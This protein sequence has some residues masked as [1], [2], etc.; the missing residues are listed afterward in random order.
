MKQFDLS[1]TIVGTFLEPDQREAIEGLGDIRVFQPGELLVRKGE[2]SDG[3]FIIVDGQ[4]FVRID[5]D[6]VSWIGPG[7]MVG[8]LGFAR[9]G[10]TRFSDVL[11]GDSGPVVVWSLSRRVI[12]HLVATGQHTKALYQLLVSLSAYME[13]RHDSVAHRSTPG[14]FTCDSAHPAIRGA[15]ASLRRETPFKTACAVWSFVR[16]FPYRF[17]FWDVAASDTF[18]LGYGMCTTKA[19]VQVA[20]MRALGL[21]ASFCRLEVNGALYASVMPSWYGARMKQRVKHYMATVLI[22]GEWVVLDGSYPTSMMIYLA[23]A[24]GYGQELLAYVSKGPE[25]I[26]HFNLML[27]TGDALAD[28]TPCPDME[29]EVSKPSMYELDNFIVMNAKLD[30]IQGFTAGH[31]EMATRAARLINQGLSEAGLLTLMTGLGAQ[32]ERIAE[33]RAIEDAHAEAPLEEAHELVI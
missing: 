10:V 25:H 26:G 11:A 22:D 17:G 6:H 15:A 3:L 32:A 13:A 14:R 5:D 12:D 21:E 18:Q 31:S 20:L 2:L 7:G 23:G 24:A 28:P 19:N 4:A 16:E 30:R 29:S 9:P 1:E 33:L 27:L 8:E